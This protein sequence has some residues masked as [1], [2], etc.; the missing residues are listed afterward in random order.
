MTRFTNSSRKWK[1]HT[2]M[3]VSIA[4]LFYLS[5]LFLIKPTRISGTSM[6]PTLQDGQA[7]VVL[8][9]GANPFLRLQRGDVVI[10]RCDETDGYLIKRMIALPGDTLEIRDNHVYLNGAVLDE[11]YIYE[12]MVTQDVPTFTLS[13][14]MCYVLGDNRNV[15]ADSRYFGPFT[16]GDIYAVVKLEHQPL[17]WIALL[18]I[19]VN[20]FVWAAYLPDWDVLE[21]DLLSLPAGEAA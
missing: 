15:S 2:V 3:C 9:V 14:D 12:Q 1:I 20:I 19:V 8:P 21:E 13:E 5:I 17:L 4:V 10:M 16:T 6:S 11:P 18:M 7:V